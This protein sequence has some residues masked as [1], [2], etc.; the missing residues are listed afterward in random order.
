[1]MILLGKSRTIIHLYSFLGRQ[2][3][4]EYNNAIVQYASKFGPTR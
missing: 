1:M 2:M 4:T 3:V